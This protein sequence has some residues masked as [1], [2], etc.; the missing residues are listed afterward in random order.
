MLPCYGRLVP[1][2]CYRRLSCQESLMGTQSKSNEEI[3]AIGIPAT[4]LV[5]VTAPGNEEGISGST[6]CIDKSWHFI[7]N[8]HVIDNAE[9]GR[10]DIRIILEPQANQ[11][12]QCLR[13]RIV[14]SDDAF[15]LATLKIDPVQALLPRESG[16]MTT[17][18]R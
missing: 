17:Y 11:M 4:A 6:F 9:E 14:R 3:V 8:A 15:D 7:T 18:P 5:E 13:N 2:N 12:R 1:C 16:M 10:A